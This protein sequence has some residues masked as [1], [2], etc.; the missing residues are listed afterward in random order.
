MGGIA[1]IVSLSL[2]LTLTLGAVAVAQTAVLELRM[3]QNGADAAR[4]FQAAEAAL[5]AAEGDIEAGNPGPLLASQAYR[6]DRP[7]QTVDW[8]DGGSEAYAVERLARIVDK[9]LVPIDVY[10]ITARGEGPAGAR[11]WL[12]STYGVALAPGADPALTGRLSWVVL[13]AW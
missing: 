12:Q 2:L 11:T 10:R 9:R 3:A 6:D 4:A 8:P 5:A 13:P 1:L 7:W